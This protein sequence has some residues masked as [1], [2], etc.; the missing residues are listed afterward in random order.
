MKYKKRILIIGRGYL[1]NKLYKDIPKDFLVDKW[2]YFKDKNDIP[3]IL[4]NFDLLI[5]ANFPSTKTENTFNSISRMK[6]KYKDNLNILNNL[7]YKINTIFL[8]S[9]RTFY[10][11]KGFNLFDYF[12]TKYNK[13]L[14]EKTKKTTD[15]YFL[16]FI[17]DQDLI[18]KE[19]SLFN[20]W[21][22]DRTL[23]NEE[24][25]IPTLSYDKFLAIFLENIEKEKNNYIFPSTLKSIKELFEIYNKCLEEF[26][27]QR[28]VNE[29]KIK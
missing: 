16:P 20:R 12:Y 23:Y 24:K 18:K 17:Y 10:K 19:G 15:H 11:V 6:K 26:Y 14:F 25:L 3:F 7:K 2:V 27:S 1:A 28:K 21:Y 8:N 13:K 29:T 5:F 9:Y 4:K 22:Q